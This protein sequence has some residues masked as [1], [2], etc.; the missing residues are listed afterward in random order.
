MDQWQKKEKEK[1]F[2]FPID[3]NPECQID[4]NPGSCPKSHT[5]DMLNWDHSEKY[6]GQP[7]A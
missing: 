7:K 6:K 2:F 5:A 1:M 3:N 4:C